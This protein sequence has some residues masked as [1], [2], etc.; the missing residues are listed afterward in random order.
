MSLKRLLKL[1]TIAT[2]VVTSGAVVG[3]AQMKDP[4][5]AT[6]D[7]SEQGQGDRVGHAG[8]MSGG[9]M[10]T[11]MM[12]FGMMDEMPMMPMRGHMMKIMFA[13]ADTDGDGAL[14]FEE[15][16]AIHKRIFNV[17]DANKDGKVTPEE[18]QAFMLGH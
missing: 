9:M 7:T 18:M 5:Q 6:D 15:V 14:S 8:M 13:I 3:L 1:A 12:Q 11:D 16:T 10:G 17:I 2:L 4:H